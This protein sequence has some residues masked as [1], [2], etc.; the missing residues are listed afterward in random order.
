MR[1]RAW[2]VCA[3]ALVA[4]GC[5]SSSAKP[6]AE[7]NGQAISVQTYNTLVHSQRLQYVSRTGYDPCGTKLVG[8]CNQLKQNAIDTLINDQLVQQYAGKHHITLS[9]DEIARQWAVVFRTSF[10]NEQAVLNAFVRRT[11]LPESFIRQSVINDQMEQKVLY[12]VT[13]NVS[14]R[15]PAVRLAQIIAANKTE[16]NLA[17]KQFH[18]GVLFGSV[19]SFLQHVSAHGCSKQACGDLGWVPYA[20]I[21]K[22]KAAVKTARIGATVGPITEGRQYDFY[23]IEGR[24]PRYKMT[25]QQQYLLRKQDFLSWLAQQRHKADVKRYVAV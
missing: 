3:L 23:F 20:F 18:D 8:I 15:T 21:P 24:D 22:Q 7:V 5:G 12:A 19:V 10:H 4:A 6:A 9:T 2:S 14:S 13:T 11:T 17:E 25:N 16:L 1:L